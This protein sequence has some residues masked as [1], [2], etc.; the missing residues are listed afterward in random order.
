MLARQ[1]SLRKCL[2]RSG[3]LENIL[4]QNCPVLLAVGFLVA[5]EAIVHKRPTFSQRSSSSKPD[6]VSKQL[7]L[8]VPTFEVYTDTPY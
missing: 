7:Y 6:T 2:A 1:R 4:S 8:L 3:V 5:A